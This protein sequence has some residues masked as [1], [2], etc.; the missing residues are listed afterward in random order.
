MT[1]SNRQKQR[2]ILTRLDLLCSTPHH[3]RWSRTCPSTSPWGCRVLRPEHPNWKYIKRMLQEHYEGNTRK[4]DWTLSWMR[5]VL[6][7]YN[8]WRAIRI[9]MQCTLDG[10]TCHLP[11]R[12]F[13]TRLWRWYLQ[14]TGAGNRFMSG[15]RELR[16]NLINLRVDP[17][18][19]KPPPPPLPHSLERPG[20]NQSRQAGRQAPIEPPINLNVL[21]D[22]WINQSAFAPSHSTPPHSHSPAPGS[23]PR[24]FNW[25]MINGV[26]FF[27]L[28]FVSSSICLTNL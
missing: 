26:G 15:A 28:R 8:R 1:E 25:Q 20:P 22:T 21:P 7:R 9:S 24:S 12:W 2:S 16:V 14:T 17:K 6:S 23:F 13:T 4:R 3:C 5:T 27:V 19:S 11:Q 18:V 10:A